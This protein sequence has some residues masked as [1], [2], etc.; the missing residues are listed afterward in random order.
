VIDKMIAESGIR[1]RLKAA[2]NGLHPLKTD[3]GDYGILEDALDEINRLRDGIDAIRQYGSD[4]LR[5]PTKIADDTRDWQRDCVLEMTNRAVRVLD[6][7][8]WGAIT[9]KEGE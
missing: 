9:E 4:T 5:G 3:R 6:G 2:S 7:M 1:G 8:P